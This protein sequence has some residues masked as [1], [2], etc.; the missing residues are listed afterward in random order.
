MT[1]TAVLAGSRDLPLCFY[2]FSD[3]P[4]SDKNTQ[5]KRF[6]GTVV[7]LLIELISTN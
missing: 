7:K 1:D 2:P 6:G 5:E 4:I 3:V